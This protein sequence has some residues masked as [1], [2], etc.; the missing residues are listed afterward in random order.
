LIK[1]DRTTLLKQTAALLTKGEAMFDKALV[2]FDGSTQI[3]RILPY[4]ARFA[5]GLNMPLVL[6]SVL[7]SGPTPTLEQRRQEVD[8]HLQEVVTRLAGA[9]VEATAVVAV[10]RPVQEIVRLVEQEGC[11]LMLLLPRGEASH[12]WGALGSITEKVIQ[13]SP[14][15]ILTIPSQDGAPDRSEGLPITT[16]IVP[17]DGSSLAEMAL[18]YAEELAQKLA[19]GVL[20]ARAVSSSSVYIGTMVDM[21]YIDPQAMEVADSE[22]AD[23]LE[24][25]ATTLRAEGFAVQAQVLRTQPAPGIVALA[26]QTPQSLITLTTHGRSALARW[27]MGSVAEE[28]VETAETPVL[29]IPQHYSQLYT[30]KV[31]DLLAQTPLFAEL[32]QEELQRIAEAARLRVYQPGEVIVREGEQT[33]GCFIVLTGQV[34]VVKD[35]DTARP[36]VL[37]RM[38]PGEIFGEMAMIDDHPRSATVRALD[39]TECVGLRRSDFMAELQ[40][41][42]EI[43]VHMLPVLVRRLR[44]ARDTSVE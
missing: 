33:A 12:T 26:H 29:V 20:L 15:P 2:P 28:V 10:G 8:R 36:A 6:A 1:S 19:A 22:A 27:F 39:A 32:T 17:L 42:P 5:G 25:V 44:E 4:V 34:E 43:A 14:V 24:R 38:G 40:R 16:V 37:A 3:D 7:A 23:Y 9:G 11:N 30:L 13:A 41:T 31:A 18:P 21:P 35:A